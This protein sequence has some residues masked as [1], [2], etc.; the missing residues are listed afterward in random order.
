MSAAP[1]TQAAAKLPE[2]PDPTYI[3]HTSEE[4]GG[5][6]L[7][8]FSRSGAVDVDDIYEGGVCTECVRLYT[9][10]QMRAY[11][12]SALSANEAEVG[13]LRD[14]YDALITKID[15][16]WANYERMG[17]VCPFEGQPMIYAATLEEIH[18]ARAALTQGETK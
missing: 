8:E 15:D 7:F 1:A 16:A 9:G 3:Y 5:D 6:D 10:D 4:E 12:L 13:R 18:E 17:E 2:L 14:R 11:A